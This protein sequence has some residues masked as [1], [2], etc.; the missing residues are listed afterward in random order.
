[1]PIFIIG[2]PRSGTTLV[3]QI[4]ASHPLVFGAGEIDEVPRFS[5]RFKTVAAVDFYTDKVVPT[6]EAARELA[7]TYLAYLTSLSKGADRVTVKTLE[8]VLHLG[9]IATLFPRARI[10][11]C[12]R[13]PLDIC[14]SCYFQNFREIDFAGRWRTSAPIIALTKGLWPTGRASCPCRSTKSSTS[15]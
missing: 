11:H 8:N 12:R 4:L 14:V 10:I 5:A 7:A 15:S 2:M 3:E 13:D 1:M 9:V 6:K